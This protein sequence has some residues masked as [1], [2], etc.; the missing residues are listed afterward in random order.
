MEGINEDNLSRKLRN[1]KRYS[2]FKIKAK[3]TELIGNLTIHRIE[4]SAHKSG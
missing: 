1:I 3:Y 2:T 4:I